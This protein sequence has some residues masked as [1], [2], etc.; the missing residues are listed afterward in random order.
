[1]GK[2]LEQFD[3]R[4]VALGQHHAV[5]QFDLVFFRLLGNAGLL[6]VGGDFLGLGVGR[7]RLLELAG[8]KL[9]FQCPV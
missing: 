7:E 1:V 8:G 5:R 9:L 4:L 2:L 6:A 3:H